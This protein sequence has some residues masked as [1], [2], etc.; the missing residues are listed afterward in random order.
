MSTASLVPETRCLS[1][2]DAWTTLRRTGRRRLLKDAFMRMR[3]SDGFS[4]A[5]S[6]AF[7]T[8]LVAVQGVIAIVGIASYIGGSGFSDVVVATVQRALPGPAGAVITAAVEQAHANGATHRWVPVVVGAIG[9]LVTATT[10]YGQIERG[11]N[12]LYG[13]EQDRPSVQKYGRA[14]LLAVTS[15]TLTSLAFVCL[16]L[17]R[18]LFRTVSTGTWSTIW[19]VCCWPLGLAM[20]AGALTLLYH[21]CPRRRQPQLS[22]LAF[23]TAVAMFLWVLVTAGLGLFFRLS[24]SY[25]QTYGALAGMVALLLW[26]LLSSMALIF[27]AAVA[28]QLEAVREGE[29]EPQDPEKVAS[30]EPTATEELATAG[31]Q[32]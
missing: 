12:R 24:R 19:N 4:H 22:W 16:A 11:L 10:A 30:S 18:N 17:G 5:R 26:S 15:G 8:A 9:S 23:G 31:S 29:P 21:A 25:G 27:G 7:M 1:G 28:A 6:L 32:R 3:V 13:V 2:E 14:F 20:I